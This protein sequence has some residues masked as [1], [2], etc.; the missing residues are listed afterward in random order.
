MT[1]RRDP[2][3]PSIVLL[4]L[5]SARK[6]MFGCYGSSFNL[7]PN[8][9]RLTQ[10][11]LL[12]ENHYAPG[13][14]SAQAHVS[15]FTGQHSA[16]H[17]MVHNLCDVKKDLKAMP[18]LLRELGYQTYG[19]S[20]ASFIPP[21]SHED[22]FG[23]DEMLYPGKDGAV[24]SVFS[25][26]GL[27]EQLRKFPALLNI[28]KKAH[29]TLSGPER[30]I[31]ISARFFDGRESLDYL[32]SKLRMAEPD[33]PVFAYATLLHPHTPYYPP[34][35]FLDQVLRG[36]RLDPL[37]FQIQL[38]MHAYINGD[39]GAAEK[40]IESVKKCYQAELLYADHLLG[41]FVE[42]LRRERLLDSTILIITSD[43]GE[44]LGEHG[45]LNHG[46]TAW[47]ELFLTPC[48]IYY[49]DKIVP[50]SSITTLTSGL[51]LMP[52]IFDLLEKRGWLESQT[53]L[54]GQ[55][56]FAPD[57]DPQDRYLVVDS[58]PLVLPD[59]LKQYP[60]V[61]YKGS[62]FQ[63]VIRTLRYK[64]IWQSNGEH[65]LFRVGEPELP[66]NNRYATD[67]EIVKDLHQKMLAF[68]MAIDPNFKID[69][70][71]IVLGRTAGAHLTNPLIRQELKR[72]GY[73]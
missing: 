36:E 20:K 43:H 5:D 4:N 14:G 3:Q 31:R 65:C 2:R 51:D 41:N 60:N 10:M 39:F 44:L 69:E 66:E 68:Y 61:L 35:R 62:V 53:I 50:G 30:Q 6:D 52:T 8:L 49:P 45:E 28:L 48:I 15:I 1:A 23:F 37:S 32:R 29:K 25:R 27:L 70:Y 7:T 17:G 54:D 9:D 55:S 42:S 67:V 34:K 46:G 71:P 40:A 64:Y 26:Q 33:R 38:N 63:R 21:A 22:Q 11:S 56:V 57:G 47:E 18:A 12:L 13:S 73:L 58:P 19:H 16:R 72:L 59:R 24:A